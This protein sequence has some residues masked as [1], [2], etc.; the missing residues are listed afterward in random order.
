VT[1]P[2]RDESAGLVSR[3]IAYVLDTVV[4]LFFVSGAVAVVLVVAAVAGAH[5]RDLAIA[6]AS[7]YVL[8]LPAAMT[9]YCAVFWLLAGRTP[10]MALLGLRVVRTDGRPVR[11]FGALLRGVLLACFPVGALWLV[12]DRRH[13]AVH[14]KVARTVV[15]RPSASGDPAGRIAS[16]GAA[17]VAAPHI[18]HDVYAHETLGD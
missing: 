9:V 10:G 5:A 15:I 7:A 3:S 17:G 8:V 2:V 4:V 13:Q 16:S 18:T 14:D 1:T 6:A 12:V 11:W